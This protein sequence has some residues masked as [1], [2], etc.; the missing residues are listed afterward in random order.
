MILKLNSEHAEIK[1]IKQ[2]NAKAFRKLFDFYYPKIVSYFY[3]R[4]SDFSQSEDLAQQV[5]IN[6]WNSREKLDETKQFSSYLFTISKNKLIDF[7]RRKKEETVELDEH[8]S[9]EFEFRPLD[10]ISD[11]IL[12]LLKELP[13]QQRIT[14]LLHRLDGLSYKELSECFNISVKTVEKRVSQVLKFLRTKLC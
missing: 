5:F 2:S 12:E 1:K 9:S 4:I 11:Q 7:Y 10:K 13:D 8:V 14:F 3:T 6:V